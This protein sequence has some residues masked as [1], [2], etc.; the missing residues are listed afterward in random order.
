V[1]YSKE[2]LTLEQQTD[3]LI[4]RGLVA[5][6]DALIHRLRAVNYYRLSGYLHPYRIRDDAG[7]LTDHYMPDTHL[8]NIWRCYNFDRRLRRVLLDAIE[9]IEVAVRTRLVSHFTHAYGSFGYLEPKNLPKVKNISEYL[10][11][12]GNLAVE[13]RR[14]KKEQFVQHFTKK[15]GKDHLELPL[16]ILC[17]LMSF[18]SPLVF[19][20]TVGSTIQRAVA[21]DFGMSDKLFFSWLKALHSVR[22]TCAHHSRT[23]KRVFGIA[24]IT[25]HK[26]KFHFWN[27]RKS[28]HIGE[29][30]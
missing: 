5:H 19:A 8:E 23:W 21:E 18:G 9:H 7:G 28:E 2:P 30:L 22:N 24:P 27:D 6:R 11:W 14:A 17:E 4:G 12:R 15:Y 3:R 26:N 20:R 13:M 25:P 16:W 1:I 29:N 10:E